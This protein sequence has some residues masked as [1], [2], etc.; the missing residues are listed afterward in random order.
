MPPSPSVSL[1]PSV[2][3]E[4]LHAHDAEQCAYCVAPA[5][6]M[7]R[8]GKKRQRRSLSADDVHASEVGQQ[9]RG[10]KGG[11]GKKSGGKGK[12]KKGAAGRGAHAAVA[13]PGPGV[14]AGVGEYV[15]VA[16]I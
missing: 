4:S 10:Q 13:E 5:G 12:G 2:G 3:L 1:S 11:K 9:R 6:L 8:L 7:R 15:V 14:S 16:L